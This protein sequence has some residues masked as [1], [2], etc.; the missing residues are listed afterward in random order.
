MDLLATLSRTCQSWKSV[1]ILSPCCKAGNY[2]NSMEQ[3][4]S[5]GQEIAHIFWTQKVHYRVHK[6][7]S[8]FPVLSL[9]NQIQAAH[10]ISWLSILILSSYLLTGLLSVHFPSGFPM[11]TLNAPPFSPI[12][13]E[14]RVTSFFCIWSPVYW[15]TGKNHELPHSMTVGRHSENVCH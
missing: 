9:I 7:L 10:T 2:L 12:S 1:V 6:T 3:S 5:A 11:K 13:A 15:V 4:F 14:T 8:L